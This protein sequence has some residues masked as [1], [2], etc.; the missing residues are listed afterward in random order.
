[1]GSGS[2]VGACTTPGQRRMS[3]GLTGRRLRQ[4]LGDD[5]RRVRNAR[6]EVAIDGEP[7]GLRGGREHPQRAIDLP[8]LEA[9]A[10]PFADLRLE[11]SE[12]LGQA[13][14]HVEVAMVD[15]ADLPL[16]PAVF[17]LR[18]YTGECGHAVQHLQLRRL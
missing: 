2:G 14:A 1:M 6:R 13:Q 3:T 18:L 9:R 15:G 11:P 16:N 12:I 5:A 17:V 8:A 7:A 10:D 4:E